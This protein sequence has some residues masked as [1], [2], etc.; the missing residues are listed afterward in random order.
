MIGFYCASMVLTSLF[1]GAYR[2]V[3]TIAACLLA[4]LNPWL[5][6]STTPAYE[7]DMFGTKF[8]TAT[9]GRMLTASAAGGLLGPTAI[10]LM[11]CHTPTLRCKGL[12]PLTSQSCSETELKAKPSSLLRRQSTLCCLATR[13]AH[14]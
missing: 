11:V 10:T 14:P 3:A 9:H 5:P 13:L 8:V 1:G 6:A 2:S 12:S 7:A 4:G